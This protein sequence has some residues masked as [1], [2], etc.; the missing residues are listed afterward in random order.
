MMHPRTPHLLVLLISLGLF[1]GCAATPDADDDD[2]DNTQAAPEPWQPRA[3]SR[4]R[5]IELVESAQENFEQVDVSELRSAFI[6]THF[7]QPYAGAEQQL[8]EA[9]F[10]ALDDE[11]MDRA[12]SLAGQI[13]QENYVSLD[14]HYVAR[15]V[16]KERGD[17]RRRRRHDHLLRDLFDTIQGSG[18]GDGS[19]TAFEVISTREMHSFLALYGLDL[20]DTEFTVDGDRAYDQARVR[21]PATDKEFVL[22]FDV[23]PQW[24]RGFDGF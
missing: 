18:D 2:S 24:R 17:D 4:R 3:E 22:W 11:R 20:V 15:E 16:Y 13:L 19:K 10:E 12:L 21:N 23:T 1:A 6:E 7:Y 8:S 14:A 9:M 5:Y